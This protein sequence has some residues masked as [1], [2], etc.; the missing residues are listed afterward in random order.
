MV[1]D[2]AP[3]PSFPEPAPLPS[4]PGPPA[5]ASLPGGS[6]ITAARSL[7]GADLGGVRLVRLIAEGGMGQVYEGR[8]EK[9]RRTVAVKV[10]KPGIASAAAL[11]RFE[12]EAQVLARLRH[13]GIAQIHAAGVEEREGPAIP[14]FIM[15]YIPNAKPITRYADDLKLSTHQRL[16]LIR[17]G[18][19][20]GT[21]TPIARALHDLLSAVLTFGG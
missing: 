1:D 6:G 9:P 2:P 13:P 14:Y 10:V 20:I 4:A 19:E 7:V 5:T 11:K 12:F 21:N 8:Q 18:Q 17:I 3:T 15:E 16:V